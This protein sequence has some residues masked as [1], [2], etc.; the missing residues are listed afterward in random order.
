MQRS[1]FERDEQG[2]FWNINRNMAA[3]F[4]DP[5]T[6]LVL[7]ELIYWR[8]KYENADGSFFYS[9]KYMMKNCII[10]RKTLDRVLKQLVE[11]KIIKIELGKDRRNYFKINS[12]RIQEITSKIQT[13]KREE[14]EKRYALKNKH[15]CTKEQTC[16]HERANKG[17]NL[18][19]T[20]EKE[21]KKEDTSSS[22][23]FEIFKNHIKED[24]YYKSFK[25]EK[26]MRK[27]FEFYN[28]LSNYNHTYN[29][30]LKNYAKKKPCNKREDETFEE[31]NLREDQW[32]IDFHD[33]LER[34]I[35][36]LIK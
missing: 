5:L 36:K 19:C 33:Y 8:D 1:Q 26:V 30:L 34:C 27:V 9:A 17:I 7:K 25:P 13:A 2:G 15:V 10:K 6:V 22:S 23:D 20:K 16:M 32:Q 31:Y 4:Q 24:P 14:N 21:E 28:N 12:Q 11:E 3:Y 29:A 35:F 18:K